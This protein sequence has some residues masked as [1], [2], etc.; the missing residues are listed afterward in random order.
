MG[1]QALLGMGITEGP[2]WDWWTQM[3]FS[4]DGEEHLRLRRL[5]ARAFTPRKVE[6]M[7]PTIRDIANGLVERL[8]GQ[9]DCEFVSTFA[10]PFAIAAIGH[11]LGSKESDYDEIYRPRATWL[12]PSLGRS[13]SN[14]RG[15]RVA[16]RC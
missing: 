6:Q 15:S 5:I 14:G 1:G 12:W 4:Q 13:V 16:W 8:A 2:L 10:A 9:S 11:L 7:R 3:L